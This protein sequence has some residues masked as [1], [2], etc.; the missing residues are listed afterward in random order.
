MTN[1]SKIAHLSFIQNIISRIGSNSFFI[2]GWAITII[3]AIIALAI[4]NSERVIIYVS[5]IPVIAFWYLDSFYLRKER[6]FRMVYDKVASE[7]ENN[8]NFSMETKEFNHSVPSV[9]C[10]MVTTSTFVFYFFIL[11]AMVI[12]C[13]LINN[14]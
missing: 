8:I 5:V 10:L 4:S 7:H 9:P 2:K 14:K 13:F 3:S 12:F 6:L 1:E 11:L